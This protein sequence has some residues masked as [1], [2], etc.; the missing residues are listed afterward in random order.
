[1]SLSPS[2]VCLIA[3]HFWIEHVVSIDKPRLGALVKGSP[4]YLTLSI[5]EVSAPDIKKIGLVL[6]RVAGCRGHR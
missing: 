1:M 4:H 2:V 3:V 5:V 6:V